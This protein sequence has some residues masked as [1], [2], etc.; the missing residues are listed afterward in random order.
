LRRAVLKDKAGFMSAKPPRSILFVCLGNICRSPLAEGVFRHVAGQAG[1]NLIID[2]AGTGAWHAGNPPDPRSI[3]VAAAY[4][5]DIAMQR[6]RKVAPGDFQRFD[7]LL[8]LDRS[9]VETLVARAPAEARGKVHLFM[10][11]AGLGPR[12]VPDPYYG[13]D[14]G[15][16]AVY[17]MIREASEALS[18]KLGARAVS[19]P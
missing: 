1:A 18:A 4:G 2:S 16:E 15:F 11:Y 13:G 9:N 17:R 7:L 14:G 5:V 12:D 10:D 3:A 19:P 6:A 8:G